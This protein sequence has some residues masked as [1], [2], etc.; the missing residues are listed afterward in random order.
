MSG[1]GT[2]RVGIIDI[3]SNSVRLV[4]FSISGSAMYPTFNEKVMAGLGRGLIETGALSAPG[5]VLA[6]AALARFRSILRGLGVSSVRVVATA[7]VRVASD[8]A[9][10]AREATQ[11]VGADLSILSGLDEGRL[12]ALGVATGFHEPQGVVADLGG[13]S[14]ELFELG[15]DD[16]NGETHM[17]GPL[18]LNGDNLTDEAEIRSR[19]QDI[20]AGSDKVAGRFDTLYAV[21]GAWRAFAKIA[22]REEHYPL[23]VLHGFSLST[24]LVNKTTSYILSHQHD[25]SLVDIAGRRASKLH[26][27]AIVLDE[28][29][30]LGCAQQVVISSYGLREGLVAE[31]LGLAT[32]DSLAD[33]LASFGGLSPSEQ[34]FSAQLYGFTRSVFSE[35]SP[36][37]KTWEVENRLHEAACLLVDSAGRYHPDHRHDMAF[38]KALYA[39]LSG[40]SHIERIFIAATL[41][42]R[43]SRR[44]TVP[45]S[46]SQLLTSK[47]LRRARQVGHAMRLGTV[48]SG[49][50]GNILSLAKLEKQGERLVLCLPRRDAAMVSETVERRLNQMAD[51]LDLSAAVSLQ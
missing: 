13:S 49:Q 20:L 50:S 38:E 35:K 26:L 17:L 9:A 19:V 15:D 12:S 51:V 14:L 24:E 1:N 40:V 46:L 27:T 25:K 8:G 5:R 41:G 36:A 33:G 16:T 32:A 30:Q 21:G 44:F 39:P 28:L 18:A 31:H 6:L 48:F 23:R 10:F 7:A 37:F 47:Q 34:N 3:G 2:K 29:T 45:K 43:Y 4:I 22:M 42:W 11:I